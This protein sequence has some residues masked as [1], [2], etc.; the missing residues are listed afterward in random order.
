MSNKDTERELSFT[1]AE[2][3]AVKGALN[4]ALTNPYNAVEVERALYS[5]RDKVTEAR[6][7]DFPMKKGTKQEMVPV[8]DTEE[9]LVEYASK[10]MHR[11]VSMAELRFE[12]F[13]LECV[14]LLCG[15]D[16]LQDWSD[17][18]K[19]LAHAQKEQNDGESFNLDMFETMTDL[20]AEKT[21]PTNLGIVDGVAADVIN[22]W[23]AKQATK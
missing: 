22:A 11:P 2:L 3:D 16:A 14:K 7:H 20:L 19:T 15:R 4:A 18:I 6:K 13:T 5:A 1:E 12:P 17:K 10:F 9:K 21:F 8:L 23:K